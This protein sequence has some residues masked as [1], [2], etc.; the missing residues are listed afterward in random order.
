MWESYTVRCYSANLEVVCKQ[1][2]EEVDVGR[3]E[4]GK[5]LVLFDGR[6]LELKKL[7]TCSLSVSCGRVRSSELKQRLLTSLGLEFVCLDCGRHKTVGSKEFSGF[8]S[9]GGVVV[10]APVEY[11]SN[12]AGAGGQEFRRCGQV[13]RRSLVSR[14]EDVRLRLGGFGESH[15]GK[16]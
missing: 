4:M 16:M 10:A 3:A 14:L 9:V 8:R 6:L 7:H 12:W 1:A 5:V 2:V 11:I 15:V 13:P